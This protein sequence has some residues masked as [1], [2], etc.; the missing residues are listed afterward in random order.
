MRPHSSWFAALVASA[1]I[2]GCAASLSYTALSTEVEISSFALQEA[3]VTFYCNG[4][5]LRTVRGVSHLKPTKT[6]VP[7]CRDLSFVV[8]LFATREQSEPYE[9]IP[10]LHETDIL[11]ILIGHRVND[12]TWFAL[13]PKTPHDGST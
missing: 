8:R 9:I 4:A 6:T 11:T 7:Y 1:V 5:W 13:P 3:R 12:V 2:I 10:A